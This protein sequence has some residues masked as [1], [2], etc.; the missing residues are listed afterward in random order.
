MLLHSQSLSVESIVHGAHELSGLIAGE[1]LLECIAKDR[2]T[3]LPGDKL[4]RA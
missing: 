4:G 1:A 3:H 2:A